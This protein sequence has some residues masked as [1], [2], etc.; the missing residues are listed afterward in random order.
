MGLDFVE[1]KAY[2][3]MMILIYVVSDYEQ[4]NSLPE[5]QSVYLDLWVSISP[6][7]YWIKSRSNMEIFYYLIQRRYNSKA[8]GEQTT[9][10][11]KPIR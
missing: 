6:F 7:A 3:Q 10:G 11:L 2:L 1:L 5:N 9:K 4:T 8:E